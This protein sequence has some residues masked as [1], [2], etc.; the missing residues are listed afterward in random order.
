M[1]SRYRYRYRYIPLHSTRL[2]ST[3]HTYGNKYMLYIF[4]SLSAVAVAATRPGI[5]TAVAGT[6]VLGGEYCRIE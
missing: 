1:Y 5:V 4:T 6:A 3:R 2:D